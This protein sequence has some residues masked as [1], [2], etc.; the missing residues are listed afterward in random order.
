MTSSSRSGLRSSFSPAFSASPKARRG[1]LELDEADLE[2]V[3]ARLR[4][5][6]GPTR[7]TSAEAPAAPDTGL[8]PALSAAVALERPLILGGTSPG[9]ASPALVRLRGRPSGLGLPG[10]DRRSAGVVVA[11]P[12]SPRGHDGV[13]RPAGR[14]RSGRSS[15][16]GRSGATAATA[17]LPAAPATTAAP[18]M[19]GTAAAAIAL[20]PGARVR[21][22]Q[23][24][25]VRL[26]LNGSFSA[27]WA[28]QLISLFGD[29]LNQLALVAVVLVTTGSALASGLAFFVATL[30]NL[31]LEPDRRHV[32]RSMGPQAHDGRQRHPASGPRPPR[33][34][35]G[36]RQHRPRLP[37]DLPRHERLGVLPARARRDPAEDRARGRPA[38]REFG[39][40]GRRDD[41][42]HR[43][44]SACRRSSSRCLGTLVPLA[45]WVDAATYLASAALLSTIVY[46]AATDRARRATRRHPASGPSFRPAGDSSAANRCCSRTRCRARPA[47]SASASRSHSRRRSSG[48]LQRHRARAS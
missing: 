37:A 16:D 17:R 5:I 31:L 4:D 29:R 26:A 43:R 47:S 28:G 11:P 3:R 44:L 10:R 35:R 25:Y 36:D 1:S 19:S 46:A 18:R 22:R 27:M 8:S 21:A 13:P 9:M 34:G 6:A 40:V 32:R 42:R 2:I 33:P 7:P 24:P 45:F 38:Q 15:R 23:H 39:D 20:E 48:D 41:R 30:P 12:R 14:P